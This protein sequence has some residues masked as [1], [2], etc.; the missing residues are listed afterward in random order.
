MLV[1][2][3]KT[4][5][6]QIWQQEFLRLLLYLREGF[7]QHSLQYSQKQTERR[8]LCL[9]WLFGLFQV[10]LDVWKFSYNLFNFIVTINRF[11]N[12]LKNIQTLTDPKYVL[13]LLAILLF[14]ER[15]L[16]FSI[17]VILEPP[18]E[19]LLG[20]YGLQVFQNGLVAV[21]TFNLLKYSLLHPLFILITKL[22]CFL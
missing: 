13:K 9:F 18:C 3:S 17:N 16:S 5:R 2:E 22:R 1:H 20:K 12:P 19:C 8:I 15:I 21:L 10:Y 6:F 7:S 14:S 11:T 4:Q